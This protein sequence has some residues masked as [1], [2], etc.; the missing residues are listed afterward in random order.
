[1]IAKDQA[2]LLQVQNLTQSFKI[3]KKIVPVLKDVSLTL[4]AGETLG[5]GGESGC[6]KSTLAKAILQLPPPTSGQV[7]FNG[8]NLSKLSLKQL[9]AQRCHMQI[10]FQHPG[11]SF[12]PLFTVKQILAE[13][14]VL[15]NKRNLIK[16]QIPYL[17]ELVGLEQQLLDRYPH[18][19]SGGQKQRIAIA[20]A[21]ALNPK[22]I[23][24]DEPFSALDSST[25][26]KIMQLFTFLQKELK[27]SYLLISHDLAAL[28]NFT[29][30]LAI[31]YLGQIVETGPSE[32]VCRLP[33]HPYTQALIAAAPIADPKKEREKAPLS[34]LKEKCSLPNSSSGCPFQARCPYQMEK[35]QQV[36]PALKELLLGQFAACHLNE[37]TNHF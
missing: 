9:Q 2:P 8:I 16:A 25:Q 11:Q 3:G 29:H 5:I 17:L 7:Y 37:K 19:L 6:G 31:L 14:F 1:M 13:P 4:H 15:Q 30:R 32:Q 21:L 28:K 10:I 35:C 27:L 36:K 26:L 20:R 23:I 33:A 18:E 34:L 24:C 22:L 12:N